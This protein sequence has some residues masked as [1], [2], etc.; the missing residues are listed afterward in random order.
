MA[1]PLNFDWGRSYVTV[2]PLPLIHQVHCTCT[3][4]DRHKSSAFTTHALPAHAFTSSV[5]IMTDRVPRKKLKTPRSISS[6]FPSCVR[7]VILITVLQ[8]CECSFEFALVWKHSI[9]QQDRRDRFDLLISRRPI[10]HN[11]NTWHSR[12]FMTLLANILI[13]LGKCQPVCMSLSK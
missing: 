11:S 8:K 7:S 2:Q 1:W 5:H 12:C 13:I 10:P 4:T 3:D 9:W 6:P